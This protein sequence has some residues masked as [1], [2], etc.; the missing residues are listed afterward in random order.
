M[1][2]KRLTAA[3]ENLA[4]G[5]SR[6]QA[7][8]YWAETHGKLVANNPNLRRYH[9]YFSVP[10]AYES[11]PRPTFI[12]ISMF[13]RDDPFSV[14]TPFPAPDWAPVGPDDRQLFDR[15]PRW[16]FNGQWADIF[17]EEHVVVDGET[18]PGMINAIFMV[19]RVPGL[20]HNRLFEHW[21]QVHAP[22]AAKL[23]GLRRYTQNHAYLEAFARGAMTHDGWSEFWFDDFQ[24]FQRAAA[25]PEW[26]AMQED[27][28]SIFCPEM[29][30]V[31]GTEYVQKDETWKPRDY[32]VLGLDEAGIRERLRREGY[33]SLADDSSVPAKI[34]TAA[35]NQKLAVWTPDHLVTLDESRIDA[36]P[37][38]R[39]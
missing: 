12:G 37:E 24:S 17:G 35:I 19:N 29:G 11:E 13:W 10:E 21:S 8:H 1:T 3:N 39:A 15:S 5:R 26:Q 2:I 9:H 38:V 28:R 36:R 14:F 30:I 31:I 7:Q 27:G 18:R 20:H 16:P 23:P 33:S 4:T 34:R 6:E 32:G 22:L 25:S